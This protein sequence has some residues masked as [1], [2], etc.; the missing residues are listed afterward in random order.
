MKLSMLYVLDKGYERHEQYLRW[1]REQR[2]L[3][4]L[5]KN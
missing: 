1:I 3:D 2:Q 4:K 5:S